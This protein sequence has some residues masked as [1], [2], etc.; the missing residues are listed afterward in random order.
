MQK[1]VSDCALKIILYHNCEKILMFTFRSLS[2]YVAEGRF[3]FV[4]VYI[5]GS[6]FSYGGQFCCVVAAEVKKFGTTIPGLQQ[7]MSS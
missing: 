3:F 5:Y 4:C 1:G 2:P 7:R 6:R